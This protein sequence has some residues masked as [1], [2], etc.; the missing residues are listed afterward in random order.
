MHSAIEDMKGLMGGSAMSPQAMQAAA[1]HLDN[2]GTVMMSSLPMGFRDSYM[3][4]QQEFA[5]NS[6]VVNHLIGSS[7]TRGSSQTMAS[8]GARVAQLLTDSQTAGGN[9]EEAKALMK[10]L[11]TITPGAQ[12]MQTNLQTAL[13]AKY[14]YTYSSAPT[15]TIGGAAARVFAA[16]VRYAMKNGVMA[17]G[18]AASAAES[19]AES[20]T[21]VSIRQAANSATQQIMGMPEGQQLKQALSSFKNPGDFLNSGAVQ[22][23][24]TMYGNYKVAANPDQD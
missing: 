19:A 22:R 16:P 4:L 3:G 6:K 21:M 24:A 8:S 2:V 1:T 11:M 10:G 18:S 7:L 14:M 13:S 20:P 23:V 15:S 17:L 9:Q 12:A 5:T